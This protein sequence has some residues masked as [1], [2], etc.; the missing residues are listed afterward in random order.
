MQFYNRDNHPVPIRPRSPA[1]AQHFT[2]PLHLPVPEKILRRPH[3]VIQVYQTPTVQHTTERQPLKEWRFVKRCITEDIDPTLRL[4]IAPGLSWIARR[5]VQSA[6]L[7]GTLIIEPTP[8][9]SIMLTYACTLCGER[10]EGKEYVRSHRF[11]TSENPSNQRN[12]LCQYCLERMRVTCDFVAFLRALRDGIWKAEG[13]EGEEKAWDESVRLRERMF[14]AR[15]GTPNSYPQG[16]NWERRTSYGGK[17][18]D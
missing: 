17:V 5:S 14:W 9:N 7:D 18:V 16:Q 12:P 10:R 4:D 3:L 11:C 2:L 1:P 6:I 8:A 13:E 15:L